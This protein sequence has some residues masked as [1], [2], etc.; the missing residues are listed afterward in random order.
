MRVIKTIRKQFWLSAGLLTAMSI[1]FLFMPLASELAE[2][3]GDWSVRVLGLFFWLFALTGY[4]AIA[5][6]ND[7]RK[8]FLLKRFG[9]DIQKNFRP[10]VLC[11]F[12]NRFAEVVDIMLIIFVLAF[13]VSVFTRLRDTYYIIVLL[14][15]LVWAANMHCLFNGR[16]FRITKYDNKER[17]RL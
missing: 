10:G 17:K 8:R 12:S 5:K 15:L 2:Q 1:T 4:L 13:A 9:R 16:T 6:A 11:V 3:T 14:S 7:N